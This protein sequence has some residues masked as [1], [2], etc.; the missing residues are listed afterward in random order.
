MLVR[1]AHLFAIPALLGAIAALANCTVK[2]VDDDGFG[3]SGNVGN[4]GGDGTGNDNV[5]GLGGFGGDGSGA[6]PGVGGGGGTGNV[7]G[8]CV[9]LTGTG[10]AGQCT[11]GG[12]LPL[13]GGASVCTQEGGTDGTL[14]PPGIKFCQKVYEVFNGGPAD[15][16]FGCIDDIGVEPSNACDIDQ[17]QQCFDETV[18]ATCEQPDVVAVCDDLEMQCATAGDTTLDPSTC[19][20]LLSPFNDVGYEQWAGC[21]DDAI[22][23][24]G[25]TCKEAVEGCWQAVTA[26]QL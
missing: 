18:A 4:L 5:G 25:G 7:G 20:F 23:E 19:E 17:V 13:A 2:E 21:V 6:T 14:P 8:E 11:D 3:A 22:N 26:I 1:H 10:D 24:Q 12:A 15:Y 9:G 16:F